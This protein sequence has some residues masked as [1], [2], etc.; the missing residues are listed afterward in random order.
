MQ[1]SL[2]ML[3]CLVG[4]AALFGTGCG[5]APEETAEQQPTAEPERQVQ[6]QGIY[7]VCWSTLGG[8]V[9]P[10]TSSLKGAIYNYGNHFETTSSAFVSEG[11]Y[12]V[13]G[14]QVC[15]SGEWT[16]SSTGDLY[17]RWAGLC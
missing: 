14:H 8:Y 5:G 17:V 16:C 2:R 15:L 11:E 6:Q 1:K 7:T 10:S 12:W 4:G 9:S 3:V 13:R